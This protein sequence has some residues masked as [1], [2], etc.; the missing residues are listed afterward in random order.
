MKPWY[1]L[2]AMKLANGLRLKVLREQLLE[3]IHIFRNRNILV[4]EESFLGSLIKLWYTY[5]VYSIMVAVTGI[6]KHVVTPAVPYTLHFY[7]I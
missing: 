3:Y 1:R 6:L 4:T 5:A 7:T 2:I